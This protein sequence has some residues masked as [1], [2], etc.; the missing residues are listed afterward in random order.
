MKP[1]QQ[2]YPSNLFADE[3]HNQILTF[4]SLI[5]ESDSLIPRIYLHGGC[6]Q[7]YKILK[8]QYPSAILVINEEENHV[9]AHIDDVNYD[10]RGICTEEGFRPATPE[11]EEKCKTWGFSKNYYPSIECPHCEEPID[12]EEDS[13]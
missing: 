3:T 12:L 4:I 5:R 9:C 2:L 7:F 1:Y 10:I 11:Q 8:S 13:Y 6:Y